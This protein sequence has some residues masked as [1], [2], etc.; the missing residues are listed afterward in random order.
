MK[1]VEKYEKSRIHNF[2]KYF[3]KKYERLLTDAEF[4]YLNS[5]N[6]LENLQTY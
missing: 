2:L 3:F 1:Q 6:L 5:T 4:S